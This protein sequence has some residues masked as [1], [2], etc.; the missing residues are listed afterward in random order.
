MRKELVPTIHRVM[1]DF[2]TCKELGFFKATL[3]KDVMEEIATTKIS[4]SVHT[5]NIQSVTK[6]LRLR[7][8]REFQGSISTIEV[9]RDSRSKFVIPHL[10]DEI[11]RGEDRQFFCSAIQREQSETV[12]Y[13]VI[14]ADSSPS[15]RKAV[16]L[17][18]ESYLDCGER[19]RM[20][21]SVLSGIHSTYEY[22]S[23]DSHSP[24]AMHVEDGFLGSINAV[25]AGAPKIWLFIAPN[26]RRIFEDHIRRLF[27]DRIQEFRGRGKN[28]NCS[29]FVRHL[30]LIISPDLLDRWGINYH[31][32]ACAAGEIIVTLPET[33]HQVL[34]VGP[35][36]AEAIN[37]A[38]GFDWKGVPADY[39]FCA[40]RCPNQPPIKPEDLCIPQELL[41][42][43]DTPGNGS[44]S[45]DFSLPE[46]AI[47]SD[48]HA[49][50]PEP[51]L[52]DMGG[53]LTP[54]PY[55]P[56]NFG[57]EQFDDL[58]SETSP[59]SQHHSPDDQHG[60]YRTPPSS[61]ESRY[62]LTPGSSTIT[63]QKSAR[64]AYQ[65]DHPNENQS[66]LFSM[67]AS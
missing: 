45:T 12:R 8:T 41:D 63:G 4:Q 39:Q 2:P 52:P 65:G 59:T 64:V 33:Y 31:A 42:I 34:N 6:S 22:I 26:H 30:N 47:C 51:S 43:P 32:V 23:A 29:Q 25:F 61:S 3:G 50:D 18:V 57:S 46:S 10:S 36:Y 66:R 16:G 55:T 40:E 5:A 49:S 13:L 35:N 15:W 21:C 19:L 28:D 9:L 11:F 48:L 1:D 53:R 62:N 7:P 37:F 27:Q 17:P 56:S 44:I 58:F 54:G 67:H 38:V 24:T 60:Q 20:T 14:P